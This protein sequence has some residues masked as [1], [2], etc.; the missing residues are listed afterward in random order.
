[1]TIE[2][3]EFLVEEPSMEEFLRGLLPRILGSTSFEVYP[4]QCKDDLLVRLPERFAGY[5]RWLP[6]SWR[7]VVV[8][9][10]DDGDCHMLKKRLEQMA[11]DAG[12]LT[13]TTARA[14]KKRGFAVVNRIAIEELEAWYFGD[15]QAVRRAFPRAPASAPMKV[16]YRDPDGIRGGTW[17]A[18]ERIMQKAG[19]FDGGLRKIEA[20]RAIAPHMDPGR[21]RSP[22]FRALCD[23]LTDMAQP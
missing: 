6:A 2:H 17:E 1:M 23:V 12:L 19:Y 4:S 20:A 7:I 14:A 22:S 8:V 10:R 18:F 21:N 11:R 5:K 13:H 15:W 3:V 9:D 16:A